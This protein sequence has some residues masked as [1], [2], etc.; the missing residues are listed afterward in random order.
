M[1]EPVQNILDTETGFRLLTKTVGMNRTY[2]IVLNPNRIREGDT[3]AAF[4]TLTQT[5]LGKVAGSVPLNIPLPS[6][7]FSGLTLQLKI[8]EGTVGEKYT[9][10]FVCTM[11]SGD[12]ITDTVTMEVV[13]G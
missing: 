10:Q 1:A 6:L 4:N 2:D 8:G 12:T 13:D 9:L 7:V 11:A 3:I 5:S